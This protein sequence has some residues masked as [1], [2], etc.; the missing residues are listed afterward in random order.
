MSI[1]LCLHVNK[2]GS[3]S[4]DPADRKTLVFPIGETYRCNIPTRT[5]QG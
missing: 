5:V 1:V 3:G 4:L 2:D